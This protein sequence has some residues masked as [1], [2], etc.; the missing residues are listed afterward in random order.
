[1][2]QNFAIAAQWVLLALIA[3]FLSI[4]LGIAV[5]LMEI[6]MGVIGGSVMTLE[7]TPWVTFLAGFGA[8]VLTFLAGAE[9][10]PDSLKQNLGESLG[11]GFLSFM[12]PFLGGMAAATTGWVG[13]SLHRRLPASPCPPLRWRSFTR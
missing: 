5:A 10:D 11:I 4:R 7:I 12:L 3:T 9:I 6:A 1:M 13:T 2:E 8:V